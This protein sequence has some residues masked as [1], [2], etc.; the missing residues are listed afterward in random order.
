MGN[1]INSNI[2]VLNSFF[3]EKSIWLNNLD[4]L[5]E[6]YKLLVQKMEKYIKAKQEFPSKTIIKKSI[7]KFIGK[8]STDN[9]KLRKRLDSIMN[10]LINQEKS[11]LTTSELED[12]LEEDYKKDIAMNNAEKLVTAISD[13]NFDLVK[14]ISNNLISVSASSATDLKGSDT[15]ELMDNIVLTDN[16]VS[17]GL[18]FGLG[19]GAEYV[20]KGS[21]INLIGQTGGGKSILALQAMINNYLKGRNQLNFNYEMDMGEISLRIKSY[22][23]KVP[24]SE[25]ESGRY[26]VSD[27]PLR[28][29][30]VSYVLKREITLEQAVDILS[31]EALEEF[32]QYPLRTNFFKIVA[33]KGDHSFK[34][35]YED[36]FLEDDLPTDLGILSYLDKYGDKVDDCYIDLITEIEFEIPTHSEANDYKVFARRLKAIAKKHSFRAWLLNQVES[37][38]SASGLLN[39]KYSKGLQQTSDLVLAV[40]SSITMAEDGTVAICI[41]KCRHGV[42]NRVILCN[43][44]FDVYTF[45]PTGDLLWISDIAEQLD[46]QFKRKKD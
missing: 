45:N 31:R 40:V 1:N 37:E 34:D 27:N 42:P 33:S 19:T 15:I 11:D 32:K 13:G 36:T 12:L 25:I 10:T 21:L 2:E 6:D 14:D 3:E 46:K 28:V 39:N 41:K 4:Y 30:A 38:S 18:D 24:A 17:S 5:N 9:I 20:P 29:K 7:P 26:S 43:R 35:G 22:I 8:D 16:K 23:S 44:A